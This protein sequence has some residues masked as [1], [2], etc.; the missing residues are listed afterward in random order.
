[1]RAAPDRGT[2][3]EIVA[4]QFPSVENRLDKAACFWRQLVEACFLFGVDQA[5]LME[6]LMQPDKLRSRILLWATPKQPPPHLT[7]RHERQ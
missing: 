4:G 1:M 5:T 3:A 6:R 7:Q 2:A